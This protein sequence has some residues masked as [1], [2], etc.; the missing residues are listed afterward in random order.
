MKKIIILVSVCFVFLCSC[1]DGS[2]SA[3]SAGGTG[4]GKGGSLARFAINGNYL[5]T[6][7]DRELEVFDISN[8]APVRVG[9]AT[10]GFGIETIFPK[11]NVLFLGSETGMYIYDISNP[12]NP[13]QLSSYEHVYAC[14][15][16]VADD[17]Y[18]YVTLR[19]IANVCGRWRNELLIVDIQDL[20]KPY[21]LKT[22]NMTSPKGL[23]IDGT[24]L[25]ICDNGLKVYDATDVSNLVKTNTFGIDCHDVIPLNGNLLVIGTNSLYQYQYKDDQMNLLSQ[26][27]VI[28]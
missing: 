14:D 6:V 19:S 3:D 18:A 26:L 7:D 1:S 22:Y 2:S 21:T 8:K 16:V 17:K 20:T 27:T 9:Q 28:E 4:A 23:G 5:Y 13:I 24:N 10:V 12:I 11:G 15:P 25:F